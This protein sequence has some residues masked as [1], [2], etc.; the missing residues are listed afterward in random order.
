MSKHELTG[1]TQAYIVKES[2]LAMKKMENSIGGNGKPIGKEAVELMIGRISNVDKND[3]LS[4]FSQSFN[5]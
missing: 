4:S 2:L 5:Q 3:Q 1:D